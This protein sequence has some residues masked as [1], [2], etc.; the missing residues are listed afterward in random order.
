MIFHTMPETEV[1]RGRGRPPKAKIDIP[2]TDSVDVVEQARLDGISW[3]NIATGLGQKQDKTIWT[4]YGDAYI[5]S[6]D[7]LTQLCL[8]DGLAN[9]IIE[10]IPQDATREGIWIDN[11]ATRKKLDREFERLGM[12]EAFFTALKFQRQY[13]GSLLIIGAMDGRTV[14]QPLNEKA[15]RTIEFLKPIDAT[16]VDLQ[17]SDWDMDPMSSTFG[18]IIR[19]SV[20]YYVK[21]QY[22]RYKI[23]YTRVLEFKNDPCPTSIFAGLQH[24]HR[25]WGISSL[26]AI[27]NSLAAMGSITQSTVNIILEFVSGTYKFKNLAALI[28][29]G[30]EAGLQKRMQALQLTASVLNARIIDSEEQFTKD[31]VQLTGLDTILD[32]FMLMLSGSTGIPI[33]RLFGRS[34]AGMNSTGESDYT[35]YLDIVQSFQKNRLKPQLRRFITLLCYAN[36][37]NPD[38][39]FAFNSLYQMSETEKATLA[40]TEAD[41]RAVD[42]DNNLRLCEAGVRDYE[43]YSKEL[44]YGAEF[45]EIEPETPPTEPPVQGGA[46]ND[47]VTK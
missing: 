30:G 32:R 34:P 1:K 21:D 10:S 22:V 47:L 15:I 41:T 16:C 43:A 38:V 4:R 39:D 31:Y 6:D 13:R 12:E 19:Y 11:E 18:K 17:D 9:R 25:Y 35:N 28:A 40:K 23:H 8:G 20:Q 36:K 7:E 2:H 45:S 24:T 3:S 26:Q 33:T 46:D 42:I 44:G 5:L 29:G 14:D 37:L 27:Y